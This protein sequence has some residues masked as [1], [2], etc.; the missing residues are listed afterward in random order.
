MDLITLALPIYNVE[1]Y[2]ERALLSALNQSYD[3][4]EFIIVDDKGKDNSM[5]IVRK[6]LSE[7]SRGKEARIIEHPENIGTGA[8]KNTAIDAAQGKYIY[9][10]DSDDEITP[11]CIEK[12]YA[13]MQEDDVDFV[14]GSYQSKLQSGE[15]IKNFICDNPSIHEHLEIA[16]QFFENRN[17]SI[18]IFTWNKL[19][20][21]SLLRDNQ[22][23]CVPG[24]L[25]EDN[26][27]SF[28]VFLK[29]LSCS[30]L[31]DITYFHYDI[32][33]STMKRVHNASSRFAR[34]YTEII[35]FEWEFA[36]N[37]RK[38]RIYESLLAYIVFYT[39]YSATEIGKSKMINPSEKVEFLKK[40]SVFPVQLKEIL[41]L[42]RKRFF[43]IIVWLI[44]KMPFRISIF[45]VSLK[46]S[47]LKKKIIN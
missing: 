32:P 43:F 14:I 36:Q 42:R 35:S 39:I 46:L 9:F 25:N 5:A 23:Y 41:R 12:L 4:I 17:K 18:P 1:K 15:I 33:N 7:H 37:Y 38:E 45:E 29:S 21:I 16:W 8:T 26:I 24:H 10:M 28:Q 13:K 44:F 19:Y 34:Q 20:K 11:D 6:A 22:I 27:F 31:S 47:V 30:F 2:V 40:I 3:N